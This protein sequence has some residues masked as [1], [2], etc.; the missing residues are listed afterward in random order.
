MRFERKR[1]QCGRIRGG[2]YFVQEIATAPQPELPDMVGPDAAEPHPANPEALPT[3]DVNLK[4]TTTTPIST[5]ECISSENDFSDPEFATWVPDE[6][7]EAVLGK[8]ARLSPVEAQI[9][10]DEWLAVWLVI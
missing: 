4:R 7:R 2:R 5:K 3:T 8:V 10:I 9:V 6:L 1:D